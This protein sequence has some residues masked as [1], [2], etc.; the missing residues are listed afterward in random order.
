SVGYE[1]VPVPNATSSGAV[2]ATL[3][4]H[5]RGYRPP[6]H[7]GDVSAEAAS[8]EV[9]QFQSQHLRWRHALIQKLNDAQQ[10]RRYL[11]RNKEQA[12]T[13]CTQV[14]LYRLPEALRTLG[15]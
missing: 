4:L 5:N 6:E 8:R 12:H 11:V 15:V 9:A 7:S 1:S 14:R 13:P 10:L 3:L 2:T